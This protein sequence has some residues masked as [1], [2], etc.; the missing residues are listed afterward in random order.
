[1]SNGRE[2]Y[3]AEFGGETCNDERNNEKHD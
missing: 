3:E 2:W 1:M